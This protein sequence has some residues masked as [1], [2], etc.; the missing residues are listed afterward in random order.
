MCD[1]KQIRF[2]II[3]LITEGMIPSKL[4]QPLANPEILTR[5]KRMNHCNCDLKKRKAYKVYHKLIDD[6]RKRLDWDEDEQFKN[7]DIT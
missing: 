3:Q 4:G 2:G 7:R 6:I 1:V 5:I